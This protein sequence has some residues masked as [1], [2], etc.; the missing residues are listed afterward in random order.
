MANKVMP[1]SKLFHAA[2]IEVQLPEG[3]DPLIKAVSDNSRLVETGSLF[4]ATRGSQTDSHLFISDA[5]ERGV[6]AVVVER[7]TP[8]YDGVVVVRVDDSRD[9]LGRL[10][11]A[12][13]GNPT[14]DMLVFGVSG[15]NGKTTTTYLIESILTAAGYKPGVIGTI[16]ARYNGKHFPAANTTPTALQLAALLAD[17]KSA[18]VNA[19][20]MEASSHA[21]DQRRIS[22]IQFDCALLTNI[23]QDHLDYHG[24]MEA[25]AEAKRLLYADHLLRPKTGS[26]RRPVPTAIFNSDDETGQAFAEAFPGAKVTFGL[27]A[28]AD[29]H[30]RD[31]TFKPSGVTFT[32]HTES[33]V[34]EVESRLLGM[35]NV[36]NILGALAAAL[37]MGL[38]REQV[39]AG[40]R[41]LENVRGRFEV[42]DA[43][44]PFTVVVD[45]AHTPDAL[46]R[47]IIN[48]R[49]MTTG[50]V[51]TVFGCGGDRDN[52]KRPIMGCTAA[53]LSDLAIVTSD[54]PRTED[55][56]KI[57]AMVMDG[58]RQAGVAEERSRMILDRRSAIGDAIST[59]QAG[60]IVVIAG[61]GHE[62]YQILGTE[63]IHFDDVEVA[64]EFLAARG[65][66]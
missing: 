35:F 17:M 48:A 63:K 18:G 61:K 40:I 6:A 4:V 59:A 24:T 5:V 19:V 55:P 32:V 11:H 25:Y 38:P 50:R 7:D 49:E 58:V 39:L 37:A 22:G 51:I 2:G 64:R 31:V 44:Q 20:A 46:E 1:L 16:E 23:T 65:Q 13:Y 36:Q 43:G 34:F 33:G 9:A 52:S 62:D 3:R 29:V 14:A 53:T 47:I 28:G 66:R 56:V 27:E 54:N 42:V 41:A 30:A 57:A 15:T 10:A 45:Y 21:M 12:Y 8:D 60:D 26:H